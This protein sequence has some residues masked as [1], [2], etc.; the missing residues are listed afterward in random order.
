[1]GSKP[2]LLL[3]VRKKRFQDGVIRSAS[4]ATHSEPGV[5]SFT[6]GFE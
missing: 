3:R 6:S 2:L 5:E 4:A 1:M